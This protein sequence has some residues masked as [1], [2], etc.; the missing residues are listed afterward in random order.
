MMLA[1][2]VHEWGHEYTNKNW[3]V[4]IRVFVAPFV[5][6]MGIPPSLLLI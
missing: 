5:D 6:G 3:P 1:K 4:L 2:A